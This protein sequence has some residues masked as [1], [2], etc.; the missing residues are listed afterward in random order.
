MAKVTAVAVYSYELVNGKWRFR[1]TGVRAGKK[2]TT[3]QS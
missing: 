2:I 1:A 3:A